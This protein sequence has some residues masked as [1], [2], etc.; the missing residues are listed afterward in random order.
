MSEKVNDMDGVVYGM[1]L[2]FQAFIVFNFDGLLNY[3]CEDIWEGFVAVLKQ[4]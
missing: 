1:C 4:D 2:K 3:F